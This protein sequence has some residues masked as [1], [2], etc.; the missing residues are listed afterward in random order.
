M[1]EITEEMKGSADKS[2]KESVAEEEENC[3]W[4]LYFLITFLANH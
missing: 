1:S 2:I 3:D 4:R